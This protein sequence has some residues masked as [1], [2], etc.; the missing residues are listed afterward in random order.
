MS[1]ARQ[2]NGPSRVVL[3]GGGHAHA[4]VALEFAKRPWPGVEVILVSE[5]PT[6]SYS[7]MYTG[8]LNGRYRLTEAEIDLVRLCEKSGLKF[9]VDRVQGLDPAA[10]TLQLESGQVMAFDW[11]SIDVGAAPDLTSI[12]GAEEHA[13]AVK[14][15]REFQA[16]VEKR[17]FAKGSSARMVQIGGGAAGCECVVA[18][19]GRAKRKRLDVSF[20][21]VDSGER[22]LHEAPEGVARAF[23]RFAE[24]EYGVK[25]FLGTRVSQVTQREVVLSNGERIQSDLVAVATSPR[26]APWVAH[27]P[28]EHSSSGFI[29]I[30]ATLRTSNP[31]IF[32]VGDVA[33]N[34]KHPHSKAG[35]YAVRAAPILAENMFRATQGRMD[36]LDFEP[37]KTWLSLMVDGQGGAFGFKGQLSLPHSRPSFWLKHQIDESFMKKFR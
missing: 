3:V 30:D 14:P 34:P 35:V 8:V 18:I 28:L 16:E 9:V 4:L 20:C 31:R 11:L 33:E 22:I 2:P 1:G 13:V 25:F 29:E 36:L 12:P 23:R 37:Q 27:L 10:R 17:V 24:R 26:P 21:I 15:L 6:S 32:A 7:G 19:A 5:R